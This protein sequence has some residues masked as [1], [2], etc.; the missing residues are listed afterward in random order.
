M[1]DIPPDQ[2][3]KIKASGVARTEVSTLGGFVIMVK[4]TTTTPI[5]AAWPMSKPKNARW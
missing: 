4:I 5:A 1:S 2:V 3:G